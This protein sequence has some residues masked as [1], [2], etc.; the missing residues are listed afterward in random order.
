MSIIER[1]SGRIPF[2]VRVGFKGVLAVPEA[3]PMT[4]P[5]SNDLRERAVRAH[6]DGEPIR[7][8]AARF[9]VSVSPVPKWTARHRAT[10]TVAPGRVGGHRPWLLE[11]HRGRVHAPV[12]ATPHLTLDRLQ[13][14]PARD[15]ITVCRDTI[16]RFLRREGLR[17]KKRRSRLS[18]CARRR[19]RPTIART[20][21]ATWRS[22][23]TLPWWSATRGPVYR[24]YSEISADSRR[25]RFV[26][27]PSTRM[28]RRTRYGPRGVGG[29][30]TARPISP[31]L[32][33]VAQS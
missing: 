31:M 29:V 33:P 19:K 13:E 7:A 24:S 25:R 4:R 17:F 8:V 32:A 5:Y 2:L 15:G 3:E 26:N 28:C 21:S 23:R 22:I 1:N 11:P 10:G 20:S 14:Q 30:R 27:C 16:W 12:A 18:R 6:H 9:E